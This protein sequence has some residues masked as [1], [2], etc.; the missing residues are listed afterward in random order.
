M[1]NSLVRCVVCDLVLPEGNNGLCEKHQYDEK[2]K[3]IKCSICG[4]FMSEYD[5]FFDSVVEVIPDSEFTSET[6]IYTH[7]LCT[8]KE[9]HDDV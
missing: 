2:P 9:R 4:Q 1:S 3:P 8:M 6:I 7:R 5:I